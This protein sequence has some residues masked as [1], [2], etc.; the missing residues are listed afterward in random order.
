MVIFTQRHKGNKEHE[1]EREKEGSFVRKITY[2]N[3]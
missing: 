3:I 1:E 2:S